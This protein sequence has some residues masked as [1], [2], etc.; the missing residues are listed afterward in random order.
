[1]AVHYL[2]AASFLSLKLLFYLSVMLYSCYCHLT[3]YCITLFFTESENESAPLSY[4]AFLTS[5]KSNVLYYITYRDHSIAIN[6][7]ATSI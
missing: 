5:E 4:G 1:M 3:D 2:M 7:P 6:I